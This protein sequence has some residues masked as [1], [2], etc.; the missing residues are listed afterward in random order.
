VNN[1]T[2]RVQISQLIQEQLRAVGMEM[3]ILILEPG[4]YGDRRPSLEYVS[5]LATWSGRAD[6]IGNMYSH[7]VTKGAN[8]FGSYSNPELDKLLET[9]RTSQDQAERTKALQAAQKIISED[10]PVVFIYHEPWIRAWSK[11][12]VGYK[13]QADGLMRFTTVSLA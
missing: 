6:P 10:S 7:F 4:P 2:Q 12:L 5:R 3:E 1:S 9:G 8:N 11:K 13:P